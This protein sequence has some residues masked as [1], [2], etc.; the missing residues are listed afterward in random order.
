MARL[1]Q[2]KQCQVHPRKAAE[3][4]AKVEKLLKAGFIYPVPLTE[5]VYNI[6]HVAKKQ[7][8]IRVCIDF[9]DLNRACP[10]EKFPTPH[11]DQIID[12]CIGSVIFSFMDGFFYYNQIEILPVDQH[13]T[14]LICPWGTFSYRN[15]PFGLKMS[16]LHSSVPS[17][18]L[19]MILN[20][21]WNPI[22][23]TSLLIH[24]SMRTT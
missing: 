21:L 19:F 12:N 20:T 23:M 16:E 17:P 8:T 11:I 2:K 22:W 24:N 3:I 10:K 6:V 14:L 4:K 15:L 7:G 9:Q 13:K 18:T 1:V 5:W